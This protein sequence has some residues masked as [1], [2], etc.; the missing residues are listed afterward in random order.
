MKHSINAEGFKKNKRKETL[1]KRW[2]AGCQSKFM[3]SNSKFGTL[4]AISTSQDAQSI[5]KK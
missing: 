1:D 5:T 4:S 3:I 2:N